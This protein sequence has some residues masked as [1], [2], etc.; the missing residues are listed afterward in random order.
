MLVESMTTFIGNVAHESTDAVGVPVTPSI[1]QMKSTRK[2][3][4]PIA[5]LQKS[6]HVS[7]YCISWFR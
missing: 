7:G 2:T 5:D 3:K 6:S 4:K 1:F